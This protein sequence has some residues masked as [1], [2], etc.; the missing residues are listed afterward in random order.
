MKE[1][2]PCGAPAV[3]A[4]ARAPGGG[5][6][7]ASTATRERSGLCYPRRALRRQATAWAPTPPDA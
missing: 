3:A 4:A 6:A 1:A 2:T 7:A 5:R